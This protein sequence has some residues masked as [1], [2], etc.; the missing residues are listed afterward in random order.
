MARGLKHRSKPRPP[1][2][3]WKRNDINIL[4][5]C[6]DYC[7]QYD[8]DFETI[9]IA[10]I[11]KR[12]G[13]QVTAQLIQRALKQETRRYG[14]EGQGTV[15][16][17]LSEG[18]IFLE[19]Y[20]DTDRKNIREQ[21][22]RIEPP[23][24]RYRLRSTSMESPSRSR[25]LSLNRPQRLE[26]SAVTNHSPPELVGL[27]VLVNKGERQT[28][29]HGSTSQR[30]NR[31]PGRER[32]RTASLPSRVKTEHGQGQC[33]GQSAE[34]LPRVSPTS[35][36]AADNGSRV[37]ELVQ[38]LQ[39]T[40]RENKEQKDYIFTLSNRL[41]EAEYECAKVRES[42]R[43][44]AEYCDDLV[45][46]R[47][48]RYENSVL[49]GQLGQMT[50]QRQTIDLAST[51]SLGPSP[52][53][54]WQEF[55]CIATDVKDA[56]SSVDITIP[57]ASAGTSAH[58]GQGS[59][60]PESES[61]MRRAAHCSLDQYLS[62]LAM[63]TSVSE[64]HIIRALVAAGISQLVFE[65]KFPDLVARESPMLD[66]YRKHIFARAGPQTL[67]QF[68]ILAYKSVIS[69]GYFVS[70]ILQTSA[71]SLANKLYNALAHLI[72]P[73]DDTMIGAEPEGG[74]VFP[75]EEA[76]S[77]NIERPV[78]SL[79]TEAFTRALT[80]KREL[81]LLKTKYKLVFFRP[82]DL[83]NT[84]T[85]IR[86][87]DGDSAFVPKRALGK[88][89]R[90]DWP[91]PRY[92]EKNSRIKLCLFPALYSRRKEELTAEFGIGVDVQNCLVD[93]DSFIADDQVDVGDGSFSL[94]AKGVVLV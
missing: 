69:E 54:I 89:V 32:T 19:G 78:A 22:G 84:D 53:T 49:K 9:A 76:H 55:E 6:L 51:G 64:F 56:C 13:K 14:R 77:S 66:Q 79:F 52:R 82:G 20:D 73:N 35:T 83:F 67:E 34:I 40:A 90:K 27:D 2:F 71:K 36:A 37:A 81:A 94:V 1:T 7:L 65:S 26:T 57:P 21:I 38:E 87:G 39:R 41:S 12:T 8:L 60:E 45:M 18:S 92:M 68:E 88:E 4:L 63:D 75:A 28:A 42:A 16:D 74:S 72:S 31:A 70:H 48:L 23:Q 44:A 85:M 17:L 24:L 93:C 46:Q 59:K 33:Q 61:W 47:D 86:D 30:G 15:Q 10:H 25:T 3:V 62:S 43:K 91:R 50:S 80:L 5:A 11:A 58:R 29:A